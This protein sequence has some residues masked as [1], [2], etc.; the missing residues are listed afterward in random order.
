MSVLPG[1]VMATQREAASGSS[2]TSRRCA[3]EQGRETGSVGCGCLRGPGPGG[4]DAGAGR[5]AGA[6]PEEH[7]R[8]AH[9]GAVLHLHEGSLRRLSARHGGVA[10]TDPR[11]HVQPGAGAPWV[12]TTTPYHLRHRVGRKNSADQSVAVHAAAARRQP[13]R[14]LCKRRRRCRAATLQGEAHAPQFQDPSELSRRATHE[15]GRYHVP[16]TTHLARCPD[17]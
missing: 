16:Q 4:T 1:R 14:V 15:S 5:V 6:H 13:G 17:V 9:R 3:R 8:N 2:S 12:G 7:A 11:R 10:T